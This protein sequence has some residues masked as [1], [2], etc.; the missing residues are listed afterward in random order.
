MCGILA[1]LQHQV[2]SNVSGV[3]F[4]IICHLKSN[5]LAPC[6]LWFDAFTGNPVVAENHVMGVKLPHFD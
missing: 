2:L 4:R 6:F 3:T 5:G 1:K